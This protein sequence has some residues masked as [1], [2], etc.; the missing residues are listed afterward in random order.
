MTTAQGQQIDA[1]YRTINSNH[2][3]LVA[4]G[5]VTFDG[6]TLNGIG[7]VDGTANPVTL[8]TVTGDVMVGIVAMCKSTVVSA[9]NSGTTAVGV[10]GDASALLAVTTTLNSQVNNSGTYYTGW[11]TAPE[12]IGNQPLEGGQ[13]IILTVAT[14]NISE[15]S[16]LFYAMWRPLS[17]G[18]TIVAA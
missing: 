1:N 5:L 3:L 15:G 8:F 16:M 13:D 12:L 14:E 10:S 17:T 7:D 2:A 6:D 11:D 4:S 18:A 9:T